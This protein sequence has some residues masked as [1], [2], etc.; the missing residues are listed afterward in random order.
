MDM[1][2]FENC[3]IALCFS[4]QT[5][6]FQYCIESVKNFFSSSKGNTYYYFGHS[7]NKNNYK[8]K[9]AEGVVVHSVL[10]EEFE[11]DELYK[12][13][14][15]AYNF[16]KLLIECEKSKVVNWGQT[17]YSQMYA[18]F[19]KQQY[20]IENNMMFDLVIRLRFDLCFPHDVKFEDYINFLIEE[21]TL[22]TN[23]GLMRN[24]YVL[25]NPSQ[26]IHFGTSLTMDLVDSFY[27]SLVNEGF[28]KLVGWN[29]ENNCFGRVGDGAMLHKWISIKNILQHNL[30]DPIPHII[31][32]LNNNHLNYKT[33]WHK[34]GNLGFFFHE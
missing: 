23:Y 33:D 27:N 22:Y 9:N 26:I 1:K 30:R 31:I 12:R 3:K 28:N 15:S 24:E 20:E 17:L 13:V 4:G 10:D 14:S 8:G 7:S 18:N 2:P 16:E 6:T 19:L 5:R 21:K 34:M 11:I 25:P 32:R 29:Q